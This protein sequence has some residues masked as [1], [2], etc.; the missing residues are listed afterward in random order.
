MRRSILR[1]IADQLAL[2]RIQRKIN[3]IRDDVRAG[4]RSMFETM[5]QLDELQ[6]QVDKIK[7]R[8]HGQEKGE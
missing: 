5:S 4:R 3:T 8:M 6:K 2:A 7:A 1:Q